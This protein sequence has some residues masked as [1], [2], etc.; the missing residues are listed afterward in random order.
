VKLNGRVV[1]CSGVKFKW[2]E[3]VPTGVV[4]WIEVYLGEF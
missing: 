4:K 2:E 1:K 3:L